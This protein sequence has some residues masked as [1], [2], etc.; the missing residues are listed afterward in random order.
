MA[1]RTRSVEAVF[2]TFINRFHSKEK[3]DGLRLHFAAPWLLIISKR[4]M[5]FEKV[6]R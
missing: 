5:I 6:V 2:I 4:T 1:V 3:N